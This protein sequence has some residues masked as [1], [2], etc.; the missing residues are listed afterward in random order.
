MEPNE[1]A[2]VELYRALNACRSLERGEYSTGCVSQQYE[3]EF[4]VRSRVDAILT[5]YKPIKER[6]QEKMYGDR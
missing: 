3:R 4:A 5:K 6:L 1:I 2:V